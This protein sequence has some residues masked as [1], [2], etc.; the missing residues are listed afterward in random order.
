MTVY[1]EWKINQRSGETVELGKQDHALPSWPTDFDS[2]I[3]GMK[4]F[5]ILRTK[6]KRNRLHHFRKVRELNRL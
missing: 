3:R 1:V 4:P 6:P 5:L 2:M